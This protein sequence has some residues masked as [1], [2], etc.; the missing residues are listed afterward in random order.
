MKSSFGRPVD[1]PET[2]ID[3][4][5]LVIDPPEPPVELSELAIDQPEAQSMSRNRQS[6]LRNP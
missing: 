1:E 6:T 2:V 5:E 4:P 3:L